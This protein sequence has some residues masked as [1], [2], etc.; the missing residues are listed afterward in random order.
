MRNQKQRFPVG[1]IVCT[2]IAVPGYKHGDQVYGKLAKGAEGIVTGHTDDERAMFDF[3][4]YVHTFNCTDGVIELTAVPNPLA[5]IKWRDAHI[6]ELERQAEKRE[7]E[8]KQ[9]LTATLTSA[10]E[11]EKILLG[12]NARITELETEVTRLRKLVYLAHDTECTC[13]ICVAMPHNPIICCICDKPIEGDDLDDRFWL[14]EIGCNPEN[15]FCYCDLECHSGCYPG[16]EHE[17]AP[18]DDEEDEELF[19]DVGFDEEPGIDELG[20]DEDEE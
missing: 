8:L 5:Q 6:A 13:E 14:H 3:Y 4:G 1:A 17:Y 12:K 11:Y 9:M 2:L 20:D 19:D 18:F 10:Q 16:H 15:G 7:A